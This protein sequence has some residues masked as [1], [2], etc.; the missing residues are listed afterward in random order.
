MRFLF[1]CKQVLT[2]YTNVYYLDQ[3]IQVYTSMAKG[4]CLVK[5]RP[6]FETCTVQTVY[7]V[8]GKYDLS[9]R[10][11]FASMPPLH[12][13]TNQHRQILAMRINILTTLLL[14]IRQKTFLHSDQSTLYCYY[15][16]G[17]KYEFQ[18]RNY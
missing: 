11:C 18:F 16:L 12:V 4:S 8:I 9:T 15:Y 2:Q 7:I 5:S 1:E 3:K 14:I 10:L 17:Q 6:G 13:S